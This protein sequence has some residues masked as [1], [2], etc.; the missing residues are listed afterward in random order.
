MSHS[1]RGKKQVHR[2]SIWEKHAGTKRRRAQKLLHHLAS[3]QRPQRTR[4]SGGWRRTPS[5]PGPGRGERREGAQNACSA[6][7][8]APGGLAPGAAARRKPRAG[9]AALHKRRAIHKSPDLNLP[10]PPPAP[11]PAP[12]RGGVGVGRAAASDLPLRGP[13]L[14]FPPRP[15]VPG[16]RAALRSLSS[17]P[18]P[19]RARSRR[20]LPLPSPRSG[21][22]L[23]KC[24]FSSV[25]CFVFLQ[26]SDK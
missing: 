19:R 13:S 17:L 25:I 4:R 9:G 6:R 5:P 7:A 15:D 20:S 11:Q 18:A 26:S 3:L 21:Y 10:L 1:H 24:S 23:M 16:L 8:G 2:E 14:P 12:P 22:R